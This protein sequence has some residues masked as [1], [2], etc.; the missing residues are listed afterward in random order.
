LFG[1]RQIRAERGDVALLH[2]Q[3]QTFMWLWSQHHGVSEK[4]DEPSA[5][6]ELL[7]NGLAS[8][9]RHRDWLQVSWLFWQP[10]KVIG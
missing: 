10:V 8:C 7:Q 5:M 4:E 2:C 9:L 1:P 6:A 3:F